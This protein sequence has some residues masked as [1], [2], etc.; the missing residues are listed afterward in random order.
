M[1]ANNFRKQK[2]YFYTIN[3]KLSIIDYYNRYN[4]AEKD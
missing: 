1:E 3:E 4:T 2:R